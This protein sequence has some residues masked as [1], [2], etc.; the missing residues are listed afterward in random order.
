MVTSDL[1]KI[2]LKMNLFTHLLLQSGIMRLSVQ[3]IDKWTRTKSCEKLRYALLH[4][5]YKVRQ[6]AADGLGL[7]KAEAAIPGL[8]LALD[9]RVKMVSMAAMTALAQISHSSEIQD[10]IQARKDGWVQKAQEERLTSES[11]RK[12]KHASTASKWE[13]PSKQTFQNVKQLLKKPMNTGKWF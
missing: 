5:P 10:R 9:D 12:T 7:L 1:S 13:R 11:V 8:L 6:K 4:G 2:D 3:N